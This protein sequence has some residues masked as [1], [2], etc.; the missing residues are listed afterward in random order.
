[1]SKK[2]VAYL[3]TAIVLVTVVVI[4]ILAPAG[5]PKPSAGSPPVSISQQVDL[6]G[7]WTSDNMSAT[8]TDSTIEILWTG[9]DFTGLYWKGTFTATVD[10]GARIFS[11]GDVNIM[12]ESMFA[13]QDTEKE[14]TYKDNSISFKRTLAGVTQIVRLTRSAG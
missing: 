12:S 9:K 8:V 5:S 4:A 11:A 10:D 13:S 1:M 6:T 3:V 7:S 14:F 2:Q